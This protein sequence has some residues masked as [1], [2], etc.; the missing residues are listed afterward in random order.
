M[1]RDWFRDQVLALGADYKVG[2]R[3]ARHSNNV[4]YTGSKGQCDWLAICTLSRAGPKHSTNCH[5]ESP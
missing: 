5:G 2:H 1:A 3:D 4:A